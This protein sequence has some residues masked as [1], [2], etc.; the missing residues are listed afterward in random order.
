MS[1]TIYKN[2]IIYKY[3]TNV[4]TRLINPSLPG[5]FHFFNFFF[6]DWEDR[7]SPSGFQRRACFLLWYYFLVISCFFFFL[8]FKFY[9]FFYTAGSYWLS[10]LYI[11]EYICQSQS[12]NSSHHHPTP[13]L[14]SPLWCP[15]VYSLHLCFNFCPANW[16]ICTIFLGSTYM[17]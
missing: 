13:Q 8:I 11:L 7:S 17:R 5:M 15:Y 4:E 1:Y 12:P 16:F 14:L 2:G 9:L 6:Q 10:I 3:Q